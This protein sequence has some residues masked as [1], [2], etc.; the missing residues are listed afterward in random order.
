MDSKVE[1]YTGRKWRTISHHPKYLIS[2]DGK[3]FSLISGRLIKLHISKHGYVYA[4]FHREKTFY[5]VHRLVAE[6]FVE[7]WFEGAEV[8]HKDECKTNNCYKN[9]EWCTRQ[10]NNNYSQ[11]PQRIAAKGGKR[12][13]ELYSKPV[14][15][16]KDGSVVY[17]F[18]SQ[19]S[20]AKH[21]QT[22]QSCIANAIKR[23]IKCRG[24]E[25]RF[26]G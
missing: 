11:I 19:T 23:N 20:A 7:G 5:Y 4:K 1:R 3:V 9:L 18:D 2:D 17:R 14:V 8:N 15:A 16:L 10:Y 13:A 6:A 26:A 24:Y 22:L 12:H 25:W 21:F